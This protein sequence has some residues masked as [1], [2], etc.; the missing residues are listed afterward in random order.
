MTPAHDERL[1]AWVA[2]RPDVRAVYARGDGLEVHYADGR[3]A[4]ASRG[5][6]DSAWVDVR[7]PGAATLRSGPRAP[8]DAFGVLAAGGAAATGEPG[9]VRAPTAG[10]LARLDVR[11]GDA[12]VPGQALAVVEVMKMQVELRADVGGQLTLGAHAAGQHVARGAVLMRITP[13]ADVSTAPSTS[14]SSL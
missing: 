11:D 7:A 10:I 6:D 14:S 2:A 3:V 5:A 1:S 13:S 4:L 8:H 9:V 12:V